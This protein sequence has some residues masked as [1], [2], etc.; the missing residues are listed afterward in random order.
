MFL[1]ASARP[2]PQ[3]LSILKTASAASTQ[4]GW[5]VEC[6]TGLLDLNRPKGLVHSSI[7]PKYWY[8]IFHC[9]KEG[10]KVGKLG[11]FGQVQILETALLVLMVSPTLAAASR[12]GGLRDI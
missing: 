8:P 7:P 6:F 9:G 5:E 11:R 4:P 12:S 2:P 3:S 10:S 1:K